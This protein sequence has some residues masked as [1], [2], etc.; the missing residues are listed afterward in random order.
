MRPPQ[1]AGESVVRRGRRRVPRTRFNEAPAVRG[2]KPAHRSAGG[3]EAEL[4]Q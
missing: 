3:R 4:L 1:F 2:G